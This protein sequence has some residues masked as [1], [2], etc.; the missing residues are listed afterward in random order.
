M[1]QLSRPFELTIGERPRVRLPPIDA[2]N[3]IT[4]PRILIMPTPEKPPTVGLQGCIKALQEEIGHLRY[5]NVKLENKW[6]ALEIQASELRSENVQIRTAQGGEQR[7]LI[8]SS[9][10]S[11]DTSSSGSLVKADDEESRGMMASNT[12][13]Q[14]V[15]VWSE[16][17]YQEALKAAE[18][19]KAQVQVLEKCY[20]E[21]MAST[22]GELETYKEEEAKR[23][24]DNNLHLLERIEWQDT[25]YTAK[26]QSNEYKRILE[27][28]VKDNKE[29]ISNA[30]GLIARMTAR[31]HDFERL[32][33]QFYT[34]PRT[35]TVL[36]WNGVS[37]TDKGTDGSRTLES[38]V[39]PPAASRKHRLDEARPKEQTTEQTTTSFGSST[40][41]KREDY[42]A[43]EGP[44]NDS[45]KHKSKRSK[46]GQAPCPSA[47]PDNALTRAGPVPSAPTKRYPNSMLKITR[48]GS[49]EA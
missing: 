29:F 16:R 5:Q 23:I 33:I 48:A 41:R 1:K 47:P 24:D 43:E 42:E 31:I 34:P 35:R 27:M 20:D 9:L 2:R 21:L 15:A 46:N 44:D 12:E 26:R 6:I 18:E 11:A 22:Q 28:Q 30:V 17:E 39:S 13:R 36:R 40:K 19:W 7:Q 25:L 4:Q 37:F 45:S 38:H 32:K 3:P 49:S 8:C 14:D 10:P